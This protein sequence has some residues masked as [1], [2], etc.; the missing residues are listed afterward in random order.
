MNLLKIKAKFL[1]LKLIYDDFMAQDSILKSGLSDYYHLITFHIPI[2]VMLFFLLIDYFLNLSLRSILKNIVSILP[3]LVGFLIA[4]LTILI[5]MDNDSLNDKPGITKKE[6]E[7]S[8]YTF[9]QIGGA[10]FLTST[11][12]ALILLVVSFFTPDKFPA[13]LLSYK[14][15]IIY[16]FKIY[17]FYLLSKFFITLLY[18]MLFLTSALKNKV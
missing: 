11:Q 4:S 18:G 9:R 8:K 15:Y 13:S 10:I 3:S 14:I 16:I 17:I 1:Q 12:V 2:L 6:K 5:S 7:A